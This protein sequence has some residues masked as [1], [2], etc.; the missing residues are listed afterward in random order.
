MTKALTLLPLLA[1]VLV[2]PVFAADSTPAAKPAAGVNAVPTPK[3]EKTITQHS[4]AID[5]QT[6]KYTATAGTLILRDDKDEPAASLFYVAY[7]KDGVTDFRH[8]PVTFLY[9]GGPGSSSIWLHM[10]A[11]GPMRV[12]TADATP[13]PPAPY[14]LVPNQYSLLDKSDLVFIDAMSTG[15]SKALGK[16]KGK[17]FWGVD[18]DV[19]AFGRFIERYVTVYNRWNSPKFLLGESYGT[20][21][22][23]NLADWLQHQGIAL[24]GVILVSSVLNYGDTFP[25][26]DLN[27]SPICPPT[28]PSPGTTT[29]CR[30]SR[31]ICR[32]S[33]NRCGSSRAVNTLMPCFRV[34]A[35]HPPN[36]MLCSP[37]YSNIPACGA[38]PEECKPAGGSGAIPRRIA[39]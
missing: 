26:T 36:T 4:V 21:R 30:T 35:C 9:N 32:P 20:T 18:E 3:E 2:A 24:N 38:V 13:T 23:A 34:P 17:D 15:F 11:F 27:T 16:A 10:G 22:S 25:G 8:R 39:A 31:R 1:L 7:T 14:D 28:P 19:K 33:C 37:N 6:I 29:S 5:G 12:M